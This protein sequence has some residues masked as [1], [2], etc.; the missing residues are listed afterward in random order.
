MRSALAD[1]IIRHSGELFNKRIQLLSLWQEIAE[2]F[3]PERADFTVNRTLG[4]DF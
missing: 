1:E 3:Y 4:E 2:N